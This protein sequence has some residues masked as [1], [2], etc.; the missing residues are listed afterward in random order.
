ME[1][2]EHD[3]IIKWFLYKEF[4]EKIQERESKKAFKKKMKKYKFVPESNRLFYCS[5]TKVCN[6]VINKIKLEPFLMVQI[7]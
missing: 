6:Q 4:P 3:S 7:T 1:D 2:D 5:T